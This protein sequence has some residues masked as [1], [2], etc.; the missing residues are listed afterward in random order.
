[1]N[2]YDV[3]FTPPDGTALFGAMRVLPRVGE[4]VELA[5]KTYE[6]LAVTHHVPEARHAGA[7]FRPWEV[8]RR[9]SVQ[10]SPAEVNHG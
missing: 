1:M 8:C 7:E 6:V 4:R 9:C 10:V 3:C 5:G 2:P